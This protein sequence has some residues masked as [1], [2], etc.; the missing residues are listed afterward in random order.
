M[1]TAYSYIRF[2]TGKQLK[3]SSLERQ[4]DMINLWLERNPGYELSTLSFQDLGVSGSTGKHLKNGFGKL[5]AAVEAGAI[6]AGDVILVEA[7]DRAGR[8]DMV[9]MLKVLTPILEAGVSLVTLDDGNV[10]T[11]QSLNESHIYMLSAKIQSAYQYSDTLSRRMKASYESRTKAAKLDNKVPKRNTPVWLTTDGKLIEELAPFV[12]Q[13]FEDYANGLGERR[14]YER[15]LKAGGDKHPEFVRM[16][17]STVKRWM[18][19]R[20]AIGEWRGITGIYPAVVTPDLFYRVQARLNEKGPA[21]SAPVKHKFTGLVVCA[22][23]GKNFNTKAY[24]YR[25]KGPIPPPVMECSSRARRGSTAC[26]NSRGIPLAVISLLFQLTC[27]E[28]VERAVA[29]QFLT[30]SQK[31]E[32]EIDGELGEV[33]KKI[34]RLVSAITTLGEDEDMSELTTAITE[35]KARRAALKVEKESLSHGTA[36]LMDRFKAEAAVAFDADAVKLNALMQSVGYQISCAM[37]GSITTP[38]GVFQYDGWSRSTD[39]YKVIRPTGKP[40]TVP[41]IRD[42]VAASTWKPGSANPSKMQTVNLQAG[43]NI[44]NAVSRSKNNS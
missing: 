40:L 36:T 28:H 34:S 7:I 38:D 37:D 15:I 6:S 31:R 1:H 14:I 2:S 20:T 21:R 39:S 35:L 42:G 44:L 16:A 30:Q 13:A 22:E 43:E 33:S 18:K 19:N 8:M 23:C 11:R 12:V 4:T 9:A 32:I 41:I 26:S 25:S 10:Y 17:P 5:L 24:T 3:G 27:W 29:G